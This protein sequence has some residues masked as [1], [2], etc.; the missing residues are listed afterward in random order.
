M[1]KSIALGVYSSMVH[2]FPFRT[3]KL[4]L[5]ALMVLPFW[6]WES[7]SMP[8][9]KS[10]FSNEGAFFV[11]QNVVLTSP[12]RGWWRGRM[13]YIKLQL[14]SIFKYIDKLSPSKRGIK[15][16]DV[17][18]SLTKACSDYASE[19]TRD[20]GRSGFILINSYLFTFFSFF[21]FF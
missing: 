11:Y 7:K 6:G 18:T 4:S 1:V 3:E 2:L 8:I 14:I 17:F 16:E 19:W 12:S 13:F 9:L 15:G 21:T 5:L 10:L 20:T